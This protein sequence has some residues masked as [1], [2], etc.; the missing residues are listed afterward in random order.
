MAQSEAPDLILMD[1]VLP[2]LDGFEATRQLKAM[3]ETRAIPVIALTA[4]AM[5][6]DRKKALAAGCDDYESKPIDFNRLLEKIEAFTG[7]EAA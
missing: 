3:P 7:P 2:V 6:D 1:L 5:A 4:Y